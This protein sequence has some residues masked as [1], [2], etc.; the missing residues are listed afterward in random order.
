MDKMLFVGVGIGLAAIIVI[1]L[2]TAVLYKTKKPVPMPA[3]KPAFCLLPK[4]SATIQLSKE[5][6]AAENS[7]A[8]LATQLESL[9]FSEASRSEQSVRFTRGSLLGD[10][11]VKIMKI[12][13]LFPLPIEPISEV[14]V[15][16]S[17]DHSRR[18]IPAIF[19][20]LRPN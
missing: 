7:V 13:L 15:Q 2:V 18:S 20:S 12:E 11:S 6:V 4:Y 9:G 17:W 10:F 14:T 3:V 1:C 19:G 5:I 16:S 8:A